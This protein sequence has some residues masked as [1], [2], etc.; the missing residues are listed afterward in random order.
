MRALSLRALREVRLGIS[1]VLLHKL[2]SFLTMLGVVCG[3]GSVIAMLAVGEG[4][5]QEAMSQIRNLGSNNILLESMKPIEEE[6]A[7]NVRVFLSVF[8][9]LYEDEQRI[10]DS[11]RDVK[12]TVPIKIIRKTGQLGDLTMELRIVGT[13]PDWFEF[14]ERPLLA[15]RTL[16]E[17]DLRGRLNTVVLTEYGARRLLATQ[18]TIG[19][20]LRLGSEAFEVVGIVRSEQVSSGDVQ[21]LD[22]NVDAYIPI[23]VARERYGDISFQVVS[24]SMRRELVELHHILV[25]VASTDRVEPTAAGI[26]QML[27]RFH[28]KTDYRISVPLSL[29]RQAE[30]TRRT[31]NIVLGSIAGISLLVGGIG[32]MNIMLA[33]VTE[34]TREIG[35]RRAIGAKRREI[36]R[37]FLIETVVLS[38]TGGL[39]GMAIGV[40][41]PF[42]ITATSGM[43]T[44]VSPWSLILSLGI[45]MAIGIIF[46]LYPAV[47]AARLDPIAALRHE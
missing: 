45:S 10:R 18:A 7:Q 3:V 9:L 47:R 44:S 43:P 22:E 31:Y 35:I 34:R 19:Q 4:A 30:A 33:S 11:F 8:G 12:R 15:G 32:I 24:G 42:A 2:R 39:I 29:L 21:A 14:V 13:S 1:N 46:G 27:K 41:I 38:T 25:E 37:Q 5:S 23:N 16:G 20:T 26:E 6:T 28:K 36:V 17:A 40:M